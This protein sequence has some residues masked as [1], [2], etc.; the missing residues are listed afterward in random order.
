MSADLL[1]YAL[2][3]AG[4]VFWL[5][6]ILGTRHGDE[7]Q[8]EN[9]LARAAL[10]PGPEAASPFAEEQRETTGEDRIKKLA[11]EEG[12]K[13]SV[14][15]A[16]I[17]LVAIARVDRE[18]DISF[19]MDGAQEAFAMIVESFA[20]GDR[21]MLK[22]LLG[23]A[24]YH[25]FEAAITARE[26]R[27]EKQ[28]TQIRAIRKAEAI[29]AKVDGRKAFVTVRFTADEVSVTRD[30]TGEIIEGHPEKVTSMRDVWTF[31]RDIKSRDPRWLVVET[32][33]DFE[34]DNKIIPNTIQ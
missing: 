26:Q 2:V 8:R 15:E 10:E 24:V 23:Q 12:G 33:G 21:E 4:L 18:F 19:F 22:D 13:V 16:E 14:A 25:A 30:S 5:R 6:S 20:A 27:G 1:V 9:P 29:E 17:G 7:R 11:A 31:S 34:D 3:A 28:D 32:R